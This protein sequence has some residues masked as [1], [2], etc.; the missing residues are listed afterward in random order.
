MK[1]VKLRLDIGCQNDERVPNVAKPQTL[2]RDTC[3]ADWPRKL[4]SGLSFIY[5]IGFICTQC[6]HIHVQTQASTSHPNPSAHKLTYISL[7]F[8][9]HTPIRL[10]L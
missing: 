2:L 7:E 8:T 5:L 10:E 1:T 4:Y 6:V 9:H 3:P